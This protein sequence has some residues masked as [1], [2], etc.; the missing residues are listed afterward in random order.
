[1]KHKIETNFKTE[2]K[3]LRYLF[4]FAFGTLNLSN[5]FPNITLNFFFKTIIKLKLKFV[6]TS[7]CFI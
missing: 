4:T 3:Y 7:K 5:Y 1:M 6:Y 2:N